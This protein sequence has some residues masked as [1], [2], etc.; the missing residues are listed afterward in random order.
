[1]IDYLGVI[2]ASVAAFAV[3][4]LWYGPLFGGRWRL[5]MNFAE[6][7]MGA[8]EGAATGQG[9]PTISAMANSFIVTLVLIWALNFLLESFSV[10]NVAGAIALSLLVSIGFIAT[11]MANSVFYERRSWGLYFINVSHYIVALAVA[12]L[13]L[14]YI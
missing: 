13:V 5:L 3:G 4:A 7:H 14:I 9:M 11:T 12:A 6:G 2:L 1:M 10:M 8:H